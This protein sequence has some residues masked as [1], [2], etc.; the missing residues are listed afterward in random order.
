MTPQS[1]PIHRWD[2][3]TLLKSL[4]IGAVVE[5]V[6]IAPAVLSPWGHA[7]PE[8][9]PG[10]VGVFLNAPG[11]ALVIFLRTLA[12]PDNG[13]STAALVVQIYV[14]QTLLI[15]YI[16]FVWLRWKQRRKAE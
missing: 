12:G 9:I 8:S 4:M 14:V 3:S 6:L 5:S 15:G 7:G 1:E 11:G 10:F 16:A 13:E 2:S